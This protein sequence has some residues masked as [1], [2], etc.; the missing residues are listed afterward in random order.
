MRCSEA[1]KNFSPYLDDELPAQD[2]ARLEAHLAQCTDCRDA[3]RRAKALSGLFAQAERFQAPPGFPA[4][5]MERIDHESVRRFSFWPALTTFAE[6][7][8][9]LLAITAGALSGGVLLDSAA[10][11]RGGAVVSALSLESFEALPPDSL[12][13]AYLAMAEERR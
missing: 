1:A 3:L 13:R 9:I 2:T 11:H 10:K 5:V 4:Q 12:G 6:A 8:A 7:A